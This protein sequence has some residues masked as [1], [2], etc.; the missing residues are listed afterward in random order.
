ML[1]VFALLGILF[2]TSCA[3]ESPTESSD[4]TG[5]IRTF[6]PITSLEDNERVLRICS[7]L[8]NKEAVLNILIASGNEYRFSF[9]QKGCSDPAL[10]TAK[11]VVTSIVQ[12]DSGFV[13]RPRSGEPFAFVDVETSTKGVLKEICNFGGTLESPILVNSGNAIWWSTFTN[14]TYCQAG[15]GTLCI[16]LQRGTTRDGMNFKIHTNEFIKFKL[17]DNDEGFFIE[18]KVISSAG[19]SG[20]NRVIMEARLK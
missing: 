10:P 19:C 11:E 2:I 16:Q 1:K 6:N 20:D 7:A 17:Q 3:V 8:R 12:T 9:A 14:A 13:F 15:F 5:E 4:S 18:R